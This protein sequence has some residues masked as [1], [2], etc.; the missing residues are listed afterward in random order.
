MRCLPSSAI[1]T[2]ISHITSDRVNGQA[3]RDELNCQCG[4][5]HLISG[6][7]HILSIIRSHRNKLFTII[8]IELNL[9]ILLFAIFLFV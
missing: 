9:L 8:R 2:S 4:W 6:R 7:T 5:L 3:R 1:N